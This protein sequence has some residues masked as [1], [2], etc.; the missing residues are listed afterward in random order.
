MTQPTCAN[1]E[2]KNGWRWYIIVTL[3]HFTLL[4]HVHM[5]VGGWGGGRHGD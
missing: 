1:Y 2:R 3:D 4:I 5:W